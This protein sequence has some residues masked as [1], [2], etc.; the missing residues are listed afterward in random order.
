MVDALLEGEKENEL[1]NERLDMRHIS[2]V[3]IVHYET[4][5]EVCGNRMNVRD[6][7]KYDAPK[8]MTLSRSL[9]SYRFPC[10]LH[11]S[12]RNGEYLTPIVCVRALVSGRT[13]APCEV[14][15]KLS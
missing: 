14:H 15:V 9:D 11:F 8:C 1:L 13:I 2:S 12:V 5:F 6:M 4:Y 10:R 3:D 7:L